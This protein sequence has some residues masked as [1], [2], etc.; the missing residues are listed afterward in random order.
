MKICMLSFNHAPADSRIYFKEALS[1]AK[2]YRSISIVAPNIEDTTDRTGRVSF[3]GFQKPPGRRGLAIGLKNIA[4]AALALDADVYHI[5]DFQV[6]YILRFLRSRCPQARF[7]YDVHEHYPDMFR[8]FAPRLSVARRIRIALLDR[9]ELSWAKRYDLILTADHAIKSRFQGVGRNISVI[10][11]YT[12]YEIRSSTV[13]MKEWRRREFDLVYCGS[14]ARAR[15]AMVVLQAICLLKPR[16]PKIRMLFLGPTYESAL[17]QEM[18]EFVK[19]QGLVEN[20]TFHGL[21]LHNEVR[22]LLEQCR[23]G[24]VPLLPI[25][26]YKKNI[27]MKQFEYMAVGLPIVGSDLPPI[28]DYLRPER[29][30]VLVDPGKPQPLADA[31]EHLFD[32]PD[33]AIEMGNRGIAAAQERYHWRFMGEKLLSH[34]RE[35]ASLQSD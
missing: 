11:N 32:D 6:N 18:K 16:F 29:T 13:Q 22:S 15:G 3:I 23:I 25:P 26:K 2:Q 31:I 17:E 20:V 21:V 1:L 9:L 14:I 28:A 10:Y 12:D 27:P 5:H 7:I 4:A 30:G 19:A 8:D 33:E 35:L 34:Y 24:L